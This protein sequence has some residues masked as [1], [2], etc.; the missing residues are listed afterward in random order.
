MPRRV[1]RISWA[2]VGG[3]LLPLHASQLLP[4]QAAGRAYL[5]CRPGSASGGWNAAFGENHVAA[6]ALT[7]AFFAFVRYSQGVDPKLL[8][9]LLSH[10]FRNG[11]CCLAL[12]CVQASAPQTRAHTLEIYRLGWSFPRFIPMPHLGPRHALKHGT[13]YYNLVAVRT[14][15]MSPKPAKLLGASKRPQAGYA[16]CLYLALHGIPIAPDEQPFTS[17]TASWPVPCSL[18]GQTPTG[19]ALQARPTAGRLPSQA[20]PAA[21]GPSAPPLQ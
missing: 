7:G 19:T 16:S 6:A 15:S 10:V 12:R 5:A 2:S 1:T 4:Q 18:Q 13:S 20:H 9:P 17:A 11:H 3:R 14:C 21:Q 8:V